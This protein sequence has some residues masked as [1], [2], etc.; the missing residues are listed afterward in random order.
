[1]DRNEIQ[2]AMIEAEA[3]GDWEAAEYFQSLLDEMDGL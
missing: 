2:D 1:M 3:R